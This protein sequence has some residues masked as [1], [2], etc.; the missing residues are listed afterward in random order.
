MNSRNVLTLLG[1]L[2]LKESLY[3]RDEPVC[4]VSTTEIVLDHQNEQSTLTTRLSN[5]YTS[6]RLATKERTGDS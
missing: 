4:P 2:T 6:C 1:I 3:H 5:P